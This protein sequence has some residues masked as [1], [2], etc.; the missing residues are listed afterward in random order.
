MASKIRQVLGKIGVA[1]WLDKVRQ[2]KRGST[3]VVHDHGSTRRCRNLQHSNPVGRAS[4]WIVE[5]LF[6]ANWGHCWGWF[7]VGNRS[8]V[9]RN[10]GVAEGR[11]FD[12]KGKG[13]SE[14]NGGWIRWFWQREGGDL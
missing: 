5:L 3:H 9:V 6:V 7:V 11:D 8:V 13:M 12:R 14:A 2:M 1:P 4:R 10:L